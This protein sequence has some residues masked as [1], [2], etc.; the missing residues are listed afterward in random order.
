[1]NLP[2]TINSFFWF[3]IKKQPWAFLVLLLTALTWSVNDT[4]TPY[5]IKVMVNTLAETKGHVVNVYRSLAYPI[6]GIITIW[7]TMEI[8]MRVQGFISVYF[9]PKFRAQ[10]REQVFNY[11]REHSFEYFANNFAGSIANKL[12]DLPSSSQ[13]VIEMLI[14][15]FIPILVLL[16]ISLFFMWQAAPLFAGIMLTW[17]V[18]HNF[19]SILFLQKGKKLWEIHSDAVTNL[20]GKMV[21]SITNIISVRLF[22]RGRFEAEYLERFQQDEIT[23]SK[24]AAW[25]IEKMRL[26]QGILGLMFVFTTFYTLIRGWSAGWV[27]LGDFSL[28]SMLSLNGLG[29]VWFISF[30]LALFTREISRMRN[31]LT[32]V[33]KRHEVVDMPNALSLRITRGEIVFDRVNFSYH[34]GSSIFKDL[35]V[36]IPPGQKVG[37]VGFTGSG[38]S[39]FI[40]LILRFY[41]IN[42]GQ[43]LID[44]QNIAK[45][46]QDS[47]RDQIAMIPQEPSLFHRSLL[48]NIR[49]GR[50][51]ATDEEVIEAAKLAHCQEFVGSLA[52][53]YQ[54]LVG[55]RGIKLSGGQRQ[56][57]AIARAILKNAPLLILDEATSALDSITEHLIQ[58]SLNRLMQGRTTIVIAHRLSTLMDMD[59]ILVFDKGKIVE[60]GSKNDLLQVN[61]YFA[62]LWNMQ[63]NGFLPEES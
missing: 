57:I 51:T 47:L 37:L 20:T 63:V 23:K 8:G 18:L 1:M 9:F 46:T 3:F 26:C 54:T 42:S 2:K 13:T 45:V 27:T 48:E 56:R 17:F 50:L 55:E 11:V 40:N 10:I 59:R 24:R 36:T 61:G 41:D 32:M 21:D 53:G 44:G 60:D 62:K 4:F 15:N 52:E 16:M 35:S 7:V 33:A 12:T 19:I 31:A 38:K 6:I 39:T 5:F 22:A 30:Q 58:E 14:F 43:I 34:K 29:M 25:H 28:I 49:Y